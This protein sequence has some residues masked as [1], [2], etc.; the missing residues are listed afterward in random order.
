MTEQGEREYSNEV[1]LRMLCEGELSQ[2]SMRAVARQLRKQ[3]TEDRIVSEEA[4]EW[5][6]N[7]TKPR[8]TREPE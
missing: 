6:K 4:D 1:L 3:L 2:E 5:L 7:R 8:G